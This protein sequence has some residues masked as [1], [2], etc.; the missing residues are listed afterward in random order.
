[1]ARCATLGIT[2]GA[3]GKHGV[4][5]ERTGKVYFEEQTVVLSLS[6]GGVAYRM[7][8]DVNDTVLAVSIVRGGEVADAQFI[9]AQAQLPTAL[10]RVRA[11]DTLEITV[12]RG[13]ELKELSTVITEGDLQYRG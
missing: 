5:N 4:Y 13:G 12:S 11:G 7:G 2:V 10:Y 6:G 3:Q 8:M 9:T 1:M